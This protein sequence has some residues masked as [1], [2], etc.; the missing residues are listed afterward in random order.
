LTEPLNPRQIVARG[1][2]QLTDRYAAW[3]TSFPDESRQRYMRI[4]LDHARGGMRLLDLGCGTG[5]TSTKR[6][7][8]VYRVTAVDISPA[9]AKAAARA[10]P[11]AQVICADM[12]Q[13]AFP[14]ESFD[15]ISAFYSLIH[16][17]RE[18]LPEFFGRVTRWLRPRGL[19]VGCLMARD[20]PADVADDW[21]GVPMYW[22]G[23]DSDRN[24]S[25]LRE[26]G[27]TVHSA[28]EE[29]VDEAGDPVTFLWVIAERP[30]L[31]V[32]STN[33]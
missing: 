31:T 4:L 3:A 27:L 11:K 12:T 1:Y 30:P 16:I 10:L 26:A 33:H 24:R 18:D 9:N 19:F 23:Y 25:I 6:L 2:D 17:P 22:S 14:P 15:A 29:S 28:V 21:L 32:L 8:D 5:V 20:T 7:T 13:L